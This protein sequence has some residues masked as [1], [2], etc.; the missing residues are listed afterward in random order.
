MNHENFILCRI[1]TESSP[2]IVLNCE[3]SFCSPCLQTYIQSKIFEAEFYS[4]NCPECKSYINDAK[5]QKILPSEDYVRFCEIKQKYFLKSHSKFRYCPKLNCKGFDISTRD[6]KL[7]CVL[8]D[9]NF[10]FNCLNEMNKDVCVVCLLKKKDKVNCRFWVWRCFSNVKRCP[11][12]KY[13]T[14]R[15]GGCRHMTCQKC[16]LEWC[17]VC[18]G[19]YSFHSY[20]RCFVGGKYYDYNWVFLLYGLIAPFSMFFTFFIYMRYRIINDDLSLSYLSISGIIYVLSFILSPIISLFYFPFLLT[21]KA[22]K[23]VKKLNS[24][25]GHWERFSYFISFFIYVFTVIGLVIAYIFLSIFL[26]PGCVV[27]MIVKVIHSIT[28]KI[29]NSYHRVNI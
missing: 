15:D 14:M 10:C 4:I 25:S 21:K 8:C 2:D 11:G 28:K 17:W 20:F 19:R 9:F 7:K 22:F 6:K 3:H 18:G 5:I 29:R 23:K 13:L 12:C 1:C 27:L 24:Y 16:K 26:P